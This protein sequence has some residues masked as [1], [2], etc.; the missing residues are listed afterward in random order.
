MII[1]YSQLADIKRQNH[2]TIVLGGGTFDLIHYGHV[3]YL[4]KL[5]E[6]GEIVVVGV[7]SDAEIAEEKGADRPI[8]PERD[9]LRMVDAIAGVDYTFIVPKFNFVSAIKKYRPDYFVTC[10]SKWEFLKNF[11]FTKVSVVPRFAGGHFKSTTSIIK[12]IQNTDFKL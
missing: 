4:K 11:D 3:Q 9:R 8:I 6:Y 12:H 10:N 7:K 2:K 1:D 5:A